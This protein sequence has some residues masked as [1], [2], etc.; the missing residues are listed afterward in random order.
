MV[1]FTEEILSGKLHFLCSENVDIFEKF[2]HSSFNN[3]IY[4]YESPS[5]LKYSSQHSYLVKHSK[6][7]LIKPT[8]LEPFQVNYEKC[9]IVLIA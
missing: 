7:Q 5:M 3:S 6:I 4:Q 2:L 8:D 1:T 9:L